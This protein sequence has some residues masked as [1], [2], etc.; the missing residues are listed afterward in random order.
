MRFDI[1]SALKTW[2]R[3][4]ETTLAVFNA[5]PEGCNEQTVT[6]G[7]GWTL[8]GLIWHICISERWFCA[9]VMGA[10]PEGEKFLPQDPMSASV[11]EMTA[12]F[13]KSHATLLQTVA[14]KDEAWIDESVDFYGN[15]W[16]RLELLHLMFRHE[17]H[18]RG[19]LSM[20]ML[21]GGGQPPTIYGAPGINL[22]DAL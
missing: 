2:A 9:D 13:Q 19:Q 12:V 6:P 8:G 20:L 18:H 5:V 1:D 7:K 11:A 15:P 22:E 3:E 14:A 16:T 10:R 4:H 17:A 21:V